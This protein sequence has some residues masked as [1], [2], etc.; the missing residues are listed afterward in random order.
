M[1]AKQQKVSVK[2]WIAVTDNPQQRDTVRHAKKVKKN[3]LIEY[4]KT[5]SSVTLTELPSG[6]RIK[7]NQKQTATIS[8]RRALLPL[9]YQFVQFRLFE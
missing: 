1:K 6:V 2:D 5:H 3:H 9:K 8:H 4:Y 7:P